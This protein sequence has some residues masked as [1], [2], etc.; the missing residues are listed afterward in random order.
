MENGLIF[1]SADDHEQSNLKKICDEIFGI[2]NALEP[3]IWKKRYQGAKEKHLVSVH[4][5]I[6]IY[7]KNKENI[8]DI[9]VPVTQEYIERYYTNRDDNSSKRGGFRTQPLEAGNSMDE[10]KNLCFTF[11]APDGRQVS[12]R[13][14]W[15]WSKEKIEDAMAH[16]EIGFV[17]DSKGGLTPFIKQYLKD[18]DGKIRKTKKQTIIDNVFTQNGTKEMERIFGKAIIYPFPKPTGLIKQ[19]LEICNVDND[20]IIL[21]FFSGSCTTAHSVFMLNAQHHKTLRWIMVQ[22][23]EPCNEKSEA[24]KNGYHSIAEIGKDRIRRASTMIKEDNPEYS[25]DFGFKVFKLDSSN[26]RA[27]NPDWNDLDKTL[28]DHTEHIVEGRTE[29]DLLYELLLKRGVELTV[30]IE[31]K[32]IADKTVYSIG[33]GV[34]LVC[35]DKAIRTGDVERLGQGIVDW[36]KELEPA[37]DAQ[38]IFRDSAFENDIAKANMTAILEQNGISHVRSL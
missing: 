25:S 12:P 19:L 2:E 38:V 26:I 4:E 14:Q 3:I 31:Q 10:R 29:E 6:L 20:D 15:V 28:L 1:I 16:G 24:Y 13:R 27:W 21:D 33:Y 32:K 37:S 11:R 23:P 22:L 9:Y 7:A 36:H 18:R 34:L 17:E 30:P 5:Y 8:G 35:L